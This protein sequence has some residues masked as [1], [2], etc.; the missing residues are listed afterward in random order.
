MR[1]SY[2]SGFGEGSVDIEQA[3]S[4]GHL[5]DLTINKLLIRNQ[6]ETQ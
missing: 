3:D 6:M 4:S 1:G 5:K 2:I